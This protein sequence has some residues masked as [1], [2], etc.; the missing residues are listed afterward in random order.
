LKF[1]G[2]HQAYFLNFTNNPFFIVN[3][4]RDKTFP[5]EIVTPYVDQI[6]RLNEN[7][8]SFMLDTFGH[9]MQWMPLVKD[10]LENFFADHLRDPFPDR[11][12]WQTEDLRY[13]RNHWVIIESLG[14]TKHNA[15]DLQDENIVMIN[16]TTQFAFKRDSVWG[17]IDMK[18]EG[19]TIHV[20]TNGVKTFILLLSPDQFDFSRPVSVYTNDLLSFQGMPQKNVST[21]LKW[22][23]RDNDR[24]ML[25]AAEIAIKTDK[26]IKT[27]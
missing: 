27:R 21:L 6:K 8:L 3:G 12:I 1:L 4:G 16:G 11:I 20:K 25:F 2:H 19:N 10:S 22:N 23:M 15:P 7:V 18:Q 9:T 17:L 14:E 24:T 13:N 26:G 5:P